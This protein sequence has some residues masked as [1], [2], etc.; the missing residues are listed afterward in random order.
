MQK[1]QRWLRWAV[2]EEQI[3][4]SLIGPTLALNTMFKGLVT[5]SVLSIFDEV[6]NSRVVI[7][8]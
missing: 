7:N 4:S 5:V 1:V 8:S 2:E 3:S 6:H